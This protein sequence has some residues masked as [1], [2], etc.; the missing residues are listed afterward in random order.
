MDKDGAKRLASAIV[1]QAVQDLDKAHKKTMRLHKACR[2]CGEC[3]TEF[4]TNYLAKHKKK[5]R[6]S[7]F[8]PFEDRYEISAV[9]FFAGEKEWREALFELCGIP[10][11]PEEFKDKIVLLEMAIK[12]CI[13]CIA[14]CKKY[15]TRRLKNERELNDAE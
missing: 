3:S 6:Y 1:L 9:R 15:A 5:S 12:E 11:P 14:K 7:Q 10:S 8:L 13:P 4:L 2:K